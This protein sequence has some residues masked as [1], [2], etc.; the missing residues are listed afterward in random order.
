ML[1]ELKYAIVFN[2]VSKALQFHFF[3]IDILKKLA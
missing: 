1:R 2:G 3:L